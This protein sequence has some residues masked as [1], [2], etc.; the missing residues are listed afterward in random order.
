MRHVSPRAILSGIL[1]AAAPLLAGCEA[2]IYRAET[3]LH[4]DGTVTRA[5]Y[6]PTADTAAE[7]R[8]PGV[9]KGTTFAKRIPHEQWSASIAE[10]PA[11][12]SDDDHP[13]FAAWGTFDSPSRV[14]S[15]FLKDEPEGLPD[16][17]L[18]IDY[19]RQD[20]VFVVDYYWNETLSDIVTLDD[21]HQARQELADMLVPLVG[22]ILDEVLGEEYETA[23]L[24]DWLHATA[25]PWAF[26]VTDVLFDLGA[27]GQLAPEETTAALE[28]V[29]ARYG[30][31]L[32][33]AAGRLADDERLRGS[34]GNTRTKSS[35]NTCTGAMASPCPTRWSTRCSSGWASRT[36][37][38]GW[39]RRRDLR[40]RASV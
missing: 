17:T 26:E 34:S 38:R 18:L 13:Y 28:P 6:Q 10:L 33:D 15:A 3:V 36:V 14:P 27:R 8:E 12:A 39:K 24:V 25:T 37:P 19:D 16:G 35:A 7:V 23:G 30:L 21:M 4:A 2:R 5:I 31:P 32:R 11:T 20:Y 1:A 9:W 29:C 22:A 40:R